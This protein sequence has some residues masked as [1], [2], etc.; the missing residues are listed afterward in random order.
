VFEFNLRHP[1]VVA[2]RVCRLVAQSY[3]ARVLKYLLA[4]F[5]VN[6]PNVIPAKLAP[7]ASI[8]M[9]SHQ[10]S[11]IALPIVT[12]YHQYYTTYPFVNEGAPNGN[13]HSSIAACAIEMGT[14]GNQVSR[15]VP[16]LD[17]MIALLHIIYHINRVIHRQKGEW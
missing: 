10:H 5:S 2:A 17:P 12:I 4:N 13:G 9:E 7:N 8:N 15:I 3:D 6:Q 1:K 11:P 16:I 14:Y